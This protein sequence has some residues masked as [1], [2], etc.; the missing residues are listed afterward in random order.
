MMVQLYRFTVQDEGVRVRG[1]IDISAVPE[2]EAVV[3]GL[4]RDEFSLDLAGVTFIDSSGVG[5]LLALHRRYAGMRIA[6]PS[7][8]VLT[9]LDLMGLTKV[10]LGER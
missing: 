1:E 3:A 5:S 10:L 4:D 7:D 8:R 2:L 6:N 9:L